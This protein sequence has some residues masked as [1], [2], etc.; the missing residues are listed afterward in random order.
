MMWADSFVARFFSC[1]F[2]CAD[3]QNVETPALKRKKI[4]ILPGKKTEFQS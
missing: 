2:R 1:C 3:A 4:L